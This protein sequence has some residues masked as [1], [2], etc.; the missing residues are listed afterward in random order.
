MTLIFK[1]IKIYDS[2]FG[3]NCQD[4][5]SHKLTFTNELQA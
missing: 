4:I 3:V 2:L 5:L 1:F